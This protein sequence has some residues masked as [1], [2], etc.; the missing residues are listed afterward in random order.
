MARWAGWT[1][2][3]WHAPCHHHTQG[4]LI[5]DDLKLDR[6]QVDKTLVR[7]FVHVIGTVSE[8]ERVMFTDFGVFAPTI[9][10]QRKARNPRTGEAV[11]VPERVIPQFR[12]AKMFK[13]EIAKHLTVATV[14]Q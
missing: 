5:A 6:S 3:L 1:R 11:T 8:G 4:E 12:P 13:D 14:E 7:F 10:G 2:D 9:R